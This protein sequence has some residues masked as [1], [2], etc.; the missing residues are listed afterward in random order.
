M[1]L[2]IRRPGDSQ[3][4]WI[5][6]AGDA[7]E[8]GVK[9]GAGAATLPDP[10]LMGADDNH[11]RTEVSAQSCRPQSGL[12]VEKPAGAW[13]CP[14]WVCM[15]EPP[16]WAQ[17]L[18]GHSDERI[19]SVQSALAAKGGPTANSTATIRDTSWRSFF[20]PW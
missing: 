9:S 18:F 8:S 1:Y 11:D 15:A 17:Q 16:A 12:A 3:G 4:E 14:Q 7:I 10:G 5:G 13:S 19:R 20:I 2:S 6:T